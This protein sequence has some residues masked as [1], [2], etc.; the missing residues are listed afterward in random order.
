M[1]LFYAVL[2]FVY[3][4]N[5]FRHVYLRARHKFSFQTHTERKIGAENWHRFQAPENGVDLWRLFWSVRHGPKVVKLSN[6]K[7]SSIFG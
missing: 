1:K 6:S 4:S 7:Y 3:F 2:S 5:I